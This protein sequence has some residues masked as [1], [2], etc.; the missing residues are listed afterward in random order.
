MGSK[1]KSES[2]NAGYVDKYGEQLLNFANSYFFPTSEASP[3]A[4]A[5]MENT[6]GAA[7]STV[8]PTNNGVPQFTRGGQPVSTTG[9]TT[10]QKGNKSAMD[11][12]ALRAF[13]PYE[14]ERVADL[15]SA[16]EQAYGNA[17]TAAGSYKNYFDTSKTGL[18]AAL[19]KYGKE[20]DP[21]AVTARDVDTT[22][23]GLDEAQKYMNPFQELALQPTIKAIELNAAK[24]RIADRAK[25]VQRGAFGGSRVALLE[26]E[27]QKNEAEA[28]GDAT[29]K[30]LAEAYDKGLTAFGTDMARKLAAD[31]S[32]Q[33]KD[34]TLGQYNESQKLKAF[35]SN[36]D[37]F[38]Q[39]ANRALQAATAAAQIAKTKSDVRTSTIDN[40]LKTGTVKQTTNQAKI[41][42]DKAAYEEQRDW[43]LKVMQ[44]YSSLIGG[45]PGVNS[46]TTTSTNPLAQ[47]TGA[48]IAA[49]SIPGTGG[50][51]A[52][53][54][55]ASD[56]RLKKDIELV[57]EVAGIK[58][59][60]FGYKAHEGR[61][62]G[63]M[64]HEVEHIPGAVFQMDDGYFAVNYGVLPVQ[65]QQIA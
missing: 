38:N 19:K 48:G 15:T 56:I 3:G 29:M 8:A 51:S 12:A 57:G 6:S 13:E 40:L 49:L 32:N 25:A 60:E 11:L 63:V 55:A 36:R 21:T 9:A 47:L 44:I 4:A 27:S 42:A 46:V 31:T 24:E 37:Q 52:I 14:G 5:A 23:W 20:Y 28:V 16:Q 54:N 45:S 1:S 64:A 30:G 34:V 2:K 18:A 26:S 33:G 62:R 35:D 41:D 65:F 10:A 53:L 50:G 43:P 39:E 7:T 22:M 59:Y 17:E 58:V 61:Y